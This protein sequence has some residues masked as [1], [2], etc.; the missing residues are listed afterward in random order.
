MDR[1]FG[2][3]YKAFVKLSRSIPLYVSYEHSIT[4]LQTGDME[5]LAFVPCDF[6]EGCSW[7]DTNTNSYCG[8]FQ[9]I[10]EP[11]A[12]ITCFELEGNNT[13]TSVVPTGRPFNGNAV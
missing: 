2:I 13:V 5:G 11:N 4:F 6:M 10:G 12:T 9:Q 1:L 3:L 8:S 7:I